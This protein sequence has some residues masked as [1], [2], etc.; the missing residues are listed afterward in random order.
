MSITS[1]G[2]FLFITQLQ[3]LAFSQCDRLHLSFTTVDLNLLHHNS[4][5]VD[6]NTSAGFKRGLSVVDLSNNESTILVDFLKTL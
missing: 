4:S 5:F 1:D 2:T 3:T 6:G